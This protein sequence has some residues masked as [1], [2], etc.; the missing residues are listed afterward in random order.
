M[1]FEYS[2]VSSCRDAINRVSTE[3]HNNCKTS[4]QPPV[5]SLLRVVRAV[6][7]A[8]FQSRVVT[9][10]AGR[11]RRRCRRLRRRPSRRCAQSSAC[12]RPR[13]K[14][15]PQRRCWKRRS[16]RH[17]RPLS[18]RSCRSLRLRCSAPA[19]VLP[20]ARRH[21]R[22]VRLRRCEPPPAA[23]TCS[24]ICSRADCAMPRP[25]LM[26]S[27]ICDAISFTAR[28]ASSLPGIT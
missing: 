22:C 12:R 7:A 13:Q 28:I 18:R 3:S 8:D 16:Q 21:I 17:F 15:R 19:A 4:L 24:A 25:S 10:W 1:R 20:A 14:S 27:A 11:D 9:I 5:S 26:A 23:P 6:A 2:Y